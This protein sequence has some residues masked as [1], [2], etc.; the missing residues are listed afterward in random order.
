M[1]QEFDSKYFEIFYRIAAVECIMSIFQVHSENDDGNTEQRK[2]VSNITFLL[3]PKLMSTL[4][5]VATSN[6]II[7]DNLIAVKN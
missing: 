4:T 7:G 2:L 5:N 6:G 1:H 3:I